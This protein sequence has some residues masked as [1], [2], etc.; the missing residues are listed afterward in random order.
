MSTN[1]DDYEVTIPQA[2]VL[3]MIMREAFNQLKGDCLEF[4]QAEAHKEHGDYGELL[5]RAAGIK[6]IGILIEVLTKE[7]HLHMG[8]KQPEGFKAAMDAND[9]LIAAARIN[10]EAYADF[11]KQNIK[12]KAS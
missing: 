3:N 12:G 8:V 4:M 5:Y 1:D 7:H 9:Q 2:E 10:I 11:Y 6:A